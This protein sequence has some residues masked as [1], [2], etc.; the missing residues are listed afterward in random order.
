MEHTE[1]S[2]FGA[3]LLFIIGGF[4]FIG[5]S[6]LASWLLRPRRPNPEKL[7]AYECGEEAIGNAWGNF[8]IKFYLVALVFIL[9]DVEIIFL[10]PWATVFGQAALIEASNGLWGWF[11]LI[12]MFI[13]IGMLAIGLAYVWAKGH[14]NWTKS[15]VQT[16]PFT[17]KVPEQLYQQINQKYERK[18]S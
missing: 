15:F 17:S 8:N 9:F 12:E 11:A 6:L 5:V 3:I 18:A 7:A 16:T 2:E 4:L 14:L 13:F 10:F 1:I